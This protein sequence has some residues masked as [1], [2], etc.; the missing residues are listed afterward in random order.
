MIFGQKENGF[1]IEIVTAT[2]IE[3]VMQ[4]ERRKGQLKASHL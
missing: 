2:Y 3:V 4:K 1:V